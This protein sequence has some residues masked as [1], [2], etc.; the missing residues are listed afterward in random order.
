MA[1]LQV[2]VKPWPGRPFR[3]QGSRAQPPKTA[4]K[5][6]LLGSVQNLWLAPSCQ[7]LPPKRMCAFSSALRAPIGVATLWVFRTVPAVATKRS[8]YPVRSAALRDCHCAVAGWGQTMDRPALPPAREQGATAKNRLHADAAGLGAK[9][10]AG[11]VLP[12]VTTETPVRF[13]QRIAGTK[14]QHVTIEGVGHFVQEQA[15]GP[16]SEAVLQFM[17]ANP[18]SPEV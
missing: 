2:G 8:F 5:R 12:V 18:R 1:P 4:C 6:T 7:W 14:Q 10:L 3:Q 16:L 13:Q 17:E 9:P 15:P 11:A